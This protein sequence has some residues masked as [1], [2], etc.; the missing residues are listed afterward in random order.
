MHGWTGTI[1]TRPST[2]THR[3]YSMLDNE[4][5]KINGEKNRTMT[6]VMYVPE[7]ITFIYMGRNWPKATPTT[8]EN[9]KNRNMV[10]KTNFTG[11]GIRGRQLMRSNANAK[12]KKNEKRNSRQLAWS[13]RLYYCCPCAS[14]LLKIHLWMA[15]NAEWKTRI[16]SDTQSAQIVANWL[17]NWWT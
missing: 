14:L 4:H 9:N 12:R 3:E 17:T 15:W 13:S 6:R 1:T 16:E 11:N 7:F 2:H 8:T 5:G 10:L